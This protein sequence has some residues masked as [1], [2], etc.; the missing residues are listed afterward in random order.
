M[1]A[2]RFLSIAISL[3]SASLLVLSGCKY[4]ATTPLWDQSY[5]A[6]PTPAIISIDPQLEAKPGISY[7][8]IHGH[9]FIVAAS[10]TVASDT[11]YVYFGTTAAVIVSENDSTIIVRSTES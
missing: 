11:T 8:T 2:Y 9:N 10:D 6:P 4:N 7:I 1:K 5:K 3:V